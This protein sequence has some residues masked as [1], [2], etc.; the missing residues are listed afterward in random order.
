MYFLIIN[1]AVNVNHLF[2]ISNFSF[3]NLI[4]VIGL[5]NCFEFLQKVLPDWMSPFSCALDDFF[6]LFVPVLHQ[7]ARYLSLHR[8]KNDRSYESG[9]GRLRTSIKKYREQNKP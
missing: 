7:I 2:N 4:N 8:C 1:F 3:K 5:R 6:V 9:L